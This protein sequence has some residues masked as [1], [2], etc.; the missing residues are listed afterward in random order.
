M[1]GLQDHELHQ[2]ISL[3]SK[4]SSLIVCINMKNALQL[5]RFLFYCKNSDTK[6][7]VLVDFY[8]DASTWCGWQNNLKVTGISPEQHIQHA[9][10]C[11][12]VI[13]ERRR[14]CRPEMTK[15]EERVY[16]YRF[17]SHIEVCEHLFDVFEVGGERGVVER[18]VP[19]PGGTALQINTETIT[20]FKFKFSRAPKDVSI[21]FV[22]SKTI[23]I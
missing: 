19:L 3:L 6:S 23:N 10:V 12:S 22:L 20:D 17:G 15:E 16:S 1:K 14:H 7:G 2:M 8:N 11:L 9:C 4:T 5:Q 18:E 13:V 21:S